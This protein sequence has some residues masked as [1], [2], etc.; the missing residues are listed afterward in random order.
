MSWGLGFLHLVVFFFFLIFCGLYMW[1]AYMAMDYMAKAY[2]VV[3]CVAIPSW[4]LQSQNKGNFGIVGKLLLE[5]LVF[6]FYTCD[7]NTIF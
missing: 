4:L 3:A 2:V 7:E 5:D 6:P 1:H